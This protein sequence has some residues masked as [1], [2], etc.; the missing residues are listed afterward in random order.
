MI[1]KIERLKNTGNFEDYNA[2]GNV[3]L[4]KMTLIYAKNPES[5]NHGTRLHCSG[6]TNL[7]NYEITNN[8][9]AGTMNSRNYGVTELRIY[10]TNYH[11]KE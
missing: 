9:C 5:R 7:W 6:I 2:S 4:D 11:D 1:T 10:G 8:C 3:S